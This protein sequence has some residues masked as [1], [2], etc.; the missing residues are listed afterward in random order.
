VPSPEEEAGPRDEEGGEEERVGEDVGS[1]FREDAGEPDSADG[2]AR[3]GE[4]EGGGSDLGKVA[5]G[6]PAGAAPCE[7]VADPS[8][9]GEVVM[10]IPPRPAEEDGDEEAEP[11]GGPVVKRARHFGGR[12]SPIINLPI[13]N[14]SAVRG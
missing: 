2:L 12:E 9:P 14:R 3:D 4:I 13:I 10:G 1:E 7:A 8:D 6:D 5:E 11:E